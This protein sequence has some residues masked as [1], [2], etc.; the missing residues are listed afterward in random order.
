M[1]LPKSLVMVRYYASLSSSLHFST[2]P[3]KNRLLTP[4]LLSLAA[5]TF[6]ETYYRALDTKR[7]TISTF[8]AAPFP[9]PLNPGQFLERADI[10]LNGNVIATPAAMQQL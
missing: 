4:S 2:L 5:T 10:S 7:D 6:I 3:T 8:Y 1:L 9:D